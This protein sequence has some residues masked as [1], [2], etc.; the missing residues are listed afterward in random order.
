M[1]CSNRFRTLR[2]LILGILTVLPGMAQAGG[3]VLVKG[4]AMSLTDDSQI[5]DIAPLNLDQNSSR[6]FAFNIEGRMN[7][8]VALG[9]EYLS[10]HHQ[11][12]L[13][14]LDS[15]RAE[16]EVIQFLAKKYFFQGGPAHPYIGIGLGVGHTDVNT[17]S[18][19]VRDNEFTFAAQLLLGFE[20]RLNNLTFLAE[21][22]HMVHDIESGGNEYNPTATGLF[23]GMG[24]NW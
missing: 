22:K 7:N 16:T 13:P 17:V 8:G 4:G 14:S 18:A 20:L 3:A 2:F 6:A 10:Y 12:T 5:V 11:F 1:K 24:F 19:V 15:G 21:I 23:F 9:A